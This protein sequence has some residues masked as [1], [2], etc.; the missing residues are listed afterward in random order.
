MARASHSHHLPSHVVDALQ[1]EAEVVGGRLAVGE[2][3]DGLHAHLAVALHGRGQL[4]EGELRHSGLATG[5]A[6]G[7]GRGVRGWGEG[8]ER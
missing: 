4:L 2:V 1:R 3:G 7:G 5:E 6:W 8:L